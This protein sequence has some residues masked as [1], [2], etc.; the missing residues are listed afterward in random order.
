[1]SK[2]KRHPTLSNQYYHLATPEL[3]LES[4]VINIAY[5]GNFY[6]KRG[7]NTFIELT[8]LLNKSFEHIFKL[9]LYSNIDALSKEDRKKLDENNVQIND[10]LS[11]TEFLNATTKYDLLL[12]NDAETTEDKPM[13]PYLPSKLSDYLGSGTPIL[14]F[15]EKDSVM[16][17]IESNLL[18]K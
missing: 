17:K 14:A 6:S 11:F 15:V 4:S 7:Y 5:F 1:K 12:I 2:I 13:N 3:N 10:Y 9:T 8:N 16:S 18:V